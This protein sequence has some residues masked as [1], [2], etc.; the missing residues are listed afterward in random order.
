MNLV[1]WA[2]IA[3]S[4]ALV[5]GVPA[6]HRTAA[7]SPTTARRVSLTLLYVS[8]VLTLLVALDGPGG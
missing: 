7:V 6:F 2:L 5:T 8:I 1:T 4:A 3:F